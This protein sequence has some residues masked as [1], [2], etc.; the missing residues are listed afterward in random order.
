MEHA[1]DD[2]DEIDE[3]DICFFEK[4]WPYPFPPDLR[5]ASSPNIVYDPKAPGG[6]RYIASLVFDAGGSSMDFEVSAEQHRIIEGYEAARK[7]Q[8]EAEANAA[9][10]R[11]APPPPPREPEPEEIPP[12]GKLTP[13]QEE[14]CRHYAAQPVATR[15]AVLAG[16]SKEN[17]AAY[18]SRLLNNA[19][20]LDRIARHRAEQGIEYVLERDTVHDKLEALFSAA[21]DDRDY[22]AAASALRLQ[23]A[24]AGLLARKPTGETTDRAQKAKKSQGASAKR[25]RKAKAKGRQKPRKA[26][27][28]Q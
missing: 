13:R 25:P 26:K 2:D 4:P 23:T 5:S 9:A 20:V 21:F 27:K 6:E 10:A 11:W 22:A 3:D 14:F 17:A 24:L 7:R 12:G 8:R 28:S 19:L 18:G 1:F 16:F 15:A